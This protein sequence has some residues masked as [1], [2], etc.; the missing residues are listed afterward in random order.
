MRK[1]MQFNWEILDECTQRAAVIG[2]WLILRLGATDVEKG[3][4]GKIVFR[5]SMT[6]VPD[7]DHEWTIV[8]AMVET[9]PVEKANKAADFAPK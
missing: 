7:R 1:K 9:P 2:G 6:F 8:P 5:E 3:K 4:L